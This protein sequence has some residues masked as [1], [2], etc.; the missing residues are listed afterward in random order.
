[1]AKSKVRNL[2]FIDGILDE[3]KYLKILKENNLKASVNKLNLP[4]NYCIRERVTIR[5]IR[6]KS[7]KN[8]TA[9]TT[10]S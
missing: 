2:T 7:L 10:K 8:G 9:S 3:A 5:S 1:M 4:E 6:L